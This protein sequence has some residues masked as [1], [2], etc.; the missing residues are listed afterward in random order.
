MKNLFFILFMSLSLI[1][2]ISSVFILIQNNQ[3]Q[4]ES[5][6]LIGLIESGFLLFIALM[7]NRKN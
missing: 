4:S 1:A 5:I 3:Q 6:A 2:F 7:I